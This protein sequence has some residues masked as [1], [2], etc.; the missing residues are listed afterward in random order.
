VILLKWNERRKKEEFKLKSCFEKDR[1]K[2][3][4]PYDETEFSTL[5]LKKRSEV[6]SRRDDRY[7]QKWK[8]GVLRENNKD[9]QSQGDISFGNTKR[10]A[11]VLSKY[12]KFM[13]EGLKSNL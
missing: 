7:N 8:F 13:E 12:S 3:D 9:I 10:G 1:I 5:E 4:T 2:Y 11:F 6:L